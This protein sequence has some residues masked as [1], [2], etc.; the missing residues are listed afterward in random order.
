[1]SWPRDTFRPPRP[2]LF[3][4]LLLATPAMAARTSAPTDIATLT[5]RATAV[6]QG[7]VVA[8][9]TTVDGPDVRTRYTVAASRVLHGQA[10]SEVTVE[11][12]GGHVGRAVVST[13]GV[14]VWTVG[15]EVVVFVEASGVPM[16]GVFTVKEDR[17]IDP[18]REAPRVR[19]NDTA[20]FES[21]IHEIVGVR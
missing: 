8:A 3:L 17:V 15:D 6:V 5:A 20:T 1:M 13:S 21:A 12:P 2:G 16:D 18:F 4:A 7:E 14:P 10:P 11:L 19:Q 9:E